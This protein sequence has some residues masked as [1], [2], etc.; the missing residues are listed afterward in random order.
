M[1][2]ARKSILK[3]TA[4][5]ARFVNEN[6][7]QSCS[8]DYCLK[9]FANVSGLF[10]HI[11]H[12]KSCSSHY[13]DVY[14]EGMR[15]EL[16][17]NSKRK[18]SEGNKD[19]IKDSTKKKYYVPMSDRLTDEGRAFQNVFRDIFQEFRRIA[20]NHIEEHLRNKPN[21]YDDEDVDKALDEA[22]D[23]L[24]WQLEREMPEDMQELENEEDNLNLYFTQI[25][26]R[27]ESY[28]TCLNA[29]PKMYWW[30]KEQERKVG[31][32]LWTFCSNKAFLTIYNADQCKQLVESS[33]DAALEEVLS[34]LIVTENY[35][36]EDLD[37]D[38]LE[39]KMS[40]AYSRL[41]KKEIVKKF[42]ETG[43][44]D[45]MR[46]LMKKLMKKR[47]YADELEYLCP[48]SE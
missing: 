21:F 31:S 7:D 27:F 8:C 1:A 29:G 30:K 25:E 41:L 43:I 24:D 38:D 44:I 14:V 40:N 18:W 3:T 9:T 34:T 5:A 6:S 45:K 4:A 2:S 46:G 20:Q 10:R 26:K 39:T 47:I 17:S 11:S 37:D 42:K 13:G 16:R 12:S 15:K 19:N 48:N 35:F 22:F 33:Q 23:F 36:E 28:L 32:E